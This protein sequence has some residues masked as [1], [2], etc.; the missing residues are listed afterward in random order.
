MYQ[1]FP[2]SMEP[3]RD[4]WRAGRGTAVKNLRV[5]VRLL[6]E[7]RGKAWVLA[8][9]LW[10]LP[11]FLL[12]AMEFSQASQIPVLAESSLSRMLGTLGGTNVAWTQM[13]I[14]LLSLVFS[15]LLAPL[16][17]YALSLLFLAERE[18]SAPSPLRV[19]GVCVRD[20]RRA[21]PLALLSFI[22]TQVLT[23]VPTLLGYLLGLLMSLLS[24][25]LAW[26]PAALG[27]LTLVSGVLMGLLN[28]FFRFLGY[29]L[30]FLVFFMV[31]KQNGRG[32]GALM[33]GIQTFRQRIGALTRAFLLCS[34]PFVIGG[35]GLWLL[36]A[37]TGYAV[38]W[39]IPAIVAPLLE[40]LGLLL[41][42]AAATEILDGGGGDAGPIYDKDVSRM[43]SANPDE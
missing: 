30:V 6:L 12:S 5:A 16:L 4:R 18:G 10:W 33:L 34:L 7:D 11:S 22:L 39:V 3:L 38:H 13:G 36:Y 26:A 14:T 27:V 21:L 9:L 28:G 23:L 40:S 2:G 15:V 20:W 24:M 1:P 35:S 32:L 31:S 42:C 17:F 43:K 41:A 29:C 25:L 8:L 37:L 19:L